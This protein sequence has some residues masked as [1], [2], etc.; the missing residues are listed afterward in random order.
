MPTREQTIA[1]A[2]QIFEHAEYPSG[3][4]V[5]TAWL[6][7]YQTLLWSEPIHLVGFDDLPHIIDAD[8]LR[9]ASAAKKR[10]WTK[11]QAWQRRA[12]VFNTY[13]AEH[14]G[15]PVGSV[16]AKTDLL[17]KQADY[18]G[19]QRQN[20]LGIAFPGLVK[21]IL[22]KFGTAAMAYK[23]E[24]E[25]T[26]IFPGVEVPGRSST[27][28]MTL[29]RYRTNCTTGTMAKASPPPAGPKTPLFRDARMPASCI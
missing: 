6:G 7:I 18:E 1:D 16:P 17:M 12:Q 24:I 25:A 28:S 23:T 22:E 5:T 11:P 8:K 21:H 9:P 27:P 26:G 29:E 13:L 14:L 15:C 4:S 2:I 10:T 19:M 20:S 3:L